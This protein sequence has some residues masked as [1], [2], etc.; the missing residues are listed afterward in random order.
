MIVT[1]SVLLFQWKPRYVVF[2]ITHSGRLQLIVYKDQPAVP[3]NEI[4][5]VPIDE[6]G[7]LE[8]NL[9]TDNEKYAFAVIMTHVTESFSADSPH[10]RTEW[11]RLLQE[12]LGKG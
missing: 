6:F 2:K 8:S 5:E 10:E 4:K 9:S 11:T 1:H 12:Y 7:G 3:A